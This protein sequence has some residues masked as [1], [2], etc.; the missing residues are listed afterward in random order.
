[1]PAWA[2]GKSCLPNLSNEIFVA[3]I[4]S[5]LNLCCTYFIGRSQ[6]KMSVYVRVGLWLIY[7]LNLIRSLN[8]PIPIKK[9]PKRSKTTGISAAKR[10]PSAAAEIRHLP[11]PPESF[12]L[13]VS[14]A[15]AM[16]P[17]THTSLE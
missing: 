11:P 16:P 10:D 12:A 7:P 8:I 15:Q 2:W 5:K 9:N 4:S 1:V 13:P 17:A 3:F 6:K 14:A